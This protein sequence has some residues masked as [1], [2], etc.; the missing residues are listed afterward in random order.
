MDARKQA[1]R[2]EAR[3]EAQRDRILAAAQQCFVRYGFH[4]ASMANIAKT[5]DMSPG[6][7]YRYFD[8]KNAIILAIIER[9]LEEARTDIGMLQTDTDLV[10]L[11]LDLFGQWQS[12]DAELMSP[13]LL[14]ETTAEA[15]RDPQ[16]AQALAAAD[17]ATGADLNAWIKDCALAA[18]RDLPDQEVE[19]RAFALRCI[20]GGLAIRA[21]REPGIDRAVLKKSLQLVLPSVVSFS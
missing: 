2:A 21:I 19:A 6:L 10:P 9:H 18:G 16:I 13:S 20:L 4:A 8:N 7:I 17:S 5:A 11:L 14:L 1:T 15:T 12:G 3:V